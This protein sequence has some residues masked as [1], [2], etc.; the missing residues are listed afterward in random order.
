MKFRLWHILALLISVVSMAAGGLVIMQEADSAALE[1]Q[2]ERI[3]YDTL[4]LE[5]QDG[6]KPATPPVVVYTP[7]SKLNDEKYALVMENTKVNLNTASLEELMAL[8]GVGDKTAQDIIDARPYTSIRELSRVPRVGEKTVVKLAP[9]ITVGKPES[10]EDLVA[11]TNEGTS[12]QPAPAKPEKPKVLIDLNTATAKELEQL[13]RVG[14]AT[15][16][17]IIEYRN[18]AGRFNSIEEIMNVKGIGPKMFEN[19]KDMLIIQDR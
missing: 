19:M 1:I 5:Y 4:E 18:Q 11:K 16:E 17:R 7:I 3:D 12:R 2:T 15:A 10:I 9:Y 8:K 13:P 14:P 6:E